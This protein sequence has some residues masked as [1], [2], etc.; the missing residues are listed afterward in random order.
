MINE[1]TMIPLIL[2]EVSKKHKIHHIKNN[3]QTNT[4]YRFGIFQI[5]S[6][7]YS[8]STIIFKK[9]KIVFESDR[10]LK[11]K[12]ILGDIETYNFPDCYFSCK[13]YILKKYIISKLKD[14]SDFLQY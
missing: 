12:I 14:L 7:D 5:N 11:I 8:I 1:Q 10:G 9:N 4:L 13:K 3:K 6:V 2:S